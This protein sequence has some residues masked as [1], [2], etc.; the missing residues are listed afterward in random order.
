MMMT[1]LL[2]KGGI[3]ESKFWLSFQIWRIYDIDVEYA[4]VI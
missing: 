2:V 1:N 4:K 3:Y